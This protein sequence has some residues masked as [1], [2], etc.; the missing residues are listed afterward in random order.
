[1]G[2]GRVYLLG[3][4]VLAHEDTLFPNLYP[5]FSIKVEVYISGVITHSLF[6]IFKRELKI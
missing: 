2:R 3:I 1:M 4:N 5:T 6:E